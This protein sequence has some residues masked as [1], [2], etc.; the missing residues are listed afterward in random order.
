MGRSQIYDR[1]QALVRI[2][3]FAA[4]LPL[5]GTLLTA[6]GRTTLG[7]EEVRSLLQACADV[8]FPEMGAAG[9]S[10]AEAVSYAILAFDKGIAGLDPAAIT[11]VESELASRTGGDFLRASAQERATVVAA[12]DSEA[13]LPGSPRSGE[14]EDWEWGWRQVKRAIVTGYYTS[15]VGGSQDLA[16]DPVPGGYED[17]RIEP[18]YRDTSNGKGPL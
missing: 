3:A 8:I 5:H 7:S 1:R 15:E 17:I 14:R 13:F 16:W 18:G 10:T 9:G 11:L 6:C 2:G 12:V 4:L